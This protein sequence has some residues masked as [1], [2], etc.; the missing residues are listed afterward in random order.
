M[1]A[2]K[3]YLV[4]MSCSSNVSTAKQ[5][6]DGIF[7]KKSEYVAHSVWFSDRN[8]VL[9]G[10]IPTTPAKLIN[11]YS[12]AKDE[13]GAAV[14]FQN[15]ACDDTFVVSGR[16]S[17]ITASFT[18]SAT[19]E[20]GPG[21]V[22]LEKAAK[23]FTGVISIFAGGPLYG[24]IGSAVDT[25]DQPVKDIIAATNK[26]PTKKSVAKDLLTGS[27]KVTTPFSDVTFQVTEITDFNA[28]IG[29]DD[30][31]KD[32]FNG[33]FANLKQG[34][35]IDADGKNLLK[36]C[37]SFASLLSDYSLEKVNQSFVLGYFA[38]YAAPDDVGNRVRCIGNRS[39]AQD[40]VDFKFFYNKSIGAYKEIKTEDVVNGF[41]EQGFNGVPLASSI[42]KPYTDTLAG[43]LRIYAVDLLAPDPSVIKDAQKHIDKLKAQVGPGPI[44]INDTTASIIDNTADGSMLNLVK[45]LLPGH[46]RFG[47]GILKPTVV[48][49]GFDALMLVLPAKTTGIALSEVVGLNLVVNATGAKF[50]DP[51]AKLVRIDI[52]NDGAAIAEAARKHPECNIT[53][54]AVAAG[55]TSDKPEKDGKG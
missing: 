47:C 4:K 50:P 5:I 43:L 44:A 41:A 1:S 49:G 20:L 17:K 2:G 35:P 37:A 52:T 26:T 25:G 39:S 40:V 23:F 15:C 8:S 46:Q 30:G 31:L 38:K 7:I 10:E 33:Q 36:Q 42:V 13:K 34:F 27:T 48:P 9:S 19:S 28:Q 6:D 55:D 11:V 22:I 29:S 53:L 18:R 16:T 54:P 51:Q 3:F 24:K 32:Q 21:A 45:N 12:L 14:G